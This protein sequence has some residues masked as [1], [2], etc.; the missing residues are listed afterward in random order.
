WSNIFIHSATSPEP[1]GRVVVEAMMAERIVIA[2]AMGGV[3]EIITD[4]NY[5]VLVDAKNAEEVREAIIKIIDNPEH[6]L[7]VAAQGRDYAVDN[8]S[9]PVLYANLEQ[10]I[11]SLR[12]ER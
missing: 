6:Y 9:L 7:R 2:S 12:I 1:F 11:H 10:F 4:S 8:F 5:G 3:L